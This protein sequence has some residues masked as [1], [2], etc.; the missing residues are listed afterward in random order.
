MRTRIALLLLSLGTAGLCSAAEPK[1]H[2][3]QLAWL[4]GTWVGATNG[5]T[6]EEIWSSPAGGGLI[7]MHKDSKGGRMT[8]YEFFRVISRDSSGVCYMA[9]PLGKPPVPFCA[10]ELNDHRV[11]FENRE[12]DFPQRVLYWLEADGRLHARIEGTLRGRA[13][14]EDWIWARKP[15]R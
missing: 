9:S 8:S 11:V 12:H 2:L 6:M 10:I 14:S 13:Q 7:G 4:E 3:E 15:A 5:L 1:G